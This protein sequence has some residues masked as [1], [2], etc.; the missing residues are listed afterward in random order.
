MACNE[1]KRID[2]MDD[3]YIT[4]KIDMFKDRNNVSRSGTRE[5]DSSGISNGEKKKLEKDHSKKYF[6]I[7]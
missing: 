1:T 3:N 2:G 5:S 7:K 6:I 4:R